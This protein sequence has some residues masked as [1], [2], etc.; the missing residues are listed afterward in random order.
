[1]CCLLIAMAGY[2][3]GILLC[4]MFC[5]SVQHGKSKLACCSC[6]YSELLTELAALEV[7]CNVNILSH[8]KLMIP[9]IP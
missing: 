3:Y 1:M 5:I 8:S 4:H 6:S 9:S 7:G 2:P